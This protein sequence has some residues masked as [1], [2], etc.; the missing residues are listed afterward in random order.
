MYINGNH[1]ATLNKTSS[2]FSKH[3]QLYIHTLYQRR[4]HLLPQSCH[5]YMSSMNPKSGRGGPSHP[6]YEDFRPTFER[7]HEEEAEKLLV[8]LPG[9]PKE[10]I[11]VST[12]GKNTVRIRGEHLVGSNVWN[13]FQEDFAAPEGC[14]MKKIRA[15]FE[16]GLLTITMPTKKLAPHE[17]ELKETPP[18]ITSQNTGEGHEK[19]DLQKPPSVQQDSPPP[20]FTSSPMQSES[21]EKDD[22]YYY[23][24]D[25]AKQK[26]K[27]EGEITCSSSAWNYMEA[28]KSL[29]EPYEKRQLLMSAGAAVLLTVAALGAAYISLQYR[30]TN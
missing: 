21:Q 3:I 24:E 10:N 4:N 14:D 27:D 6:V 22:N 7:Q 2:Q 13:R 30:E 19:A 11:R 12:E 18:P 5:I 16:N 23:Y 20:N 8:Y 25:K 15:R 1:T 9:F 29:T 26:E 17:Y 28:I